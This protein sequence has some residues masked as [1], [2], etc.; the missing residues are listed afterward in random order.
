MDKYPIALLNTLSIL[1]TLSWNSWF[2]SSLPKSANWAF[3][4]FSCRNIYVL[5]IV[6]VTCVCTYEFLLWV[7]QWDIQKEFQASDDLCISILLTSP[8]SQVTFEWLQG[9]DFQWAMDKSSS[10]LLTEEPKLL[11]TEEPKIGSHLQIT[12]Y[13]SILFKFQGPNRCYSWKLLG[14]KEA[15]ADW[16]H[17]MSCLWYS[18]ASF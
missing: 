5:V 4:S 17:S 10:E 8:V 1:Y 7:L 15:F 3:T 11:Q 18:T 14:V 9:T 2:V 6:V 13:L 12:T 16:E